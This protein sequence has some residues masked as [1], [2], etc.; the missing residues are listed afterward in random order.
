MSSPIFEL[1]FPPQTTPVM[2]CDHCSQ[3]NHYK[4]TKDLH[5]ARS[6]FQSVFYSA[7]QQCLIVDHALLEIFSLLEFPD[8]TRASH[9]NSCNFFISFSDFHLFLKLL[10]LKVSGFKAEPFLH[11]TNSLLG[12]TQWLKFYMPC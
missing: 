6:K 8:G 12:F 2:L 11:L 9:P 4:V 7:A 5:V 3:Q 1:T 10:M